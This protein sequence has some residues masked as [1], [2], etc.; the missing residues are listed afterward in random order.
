MAHPDRTPGRRRVA[1][2]LAA[3]TQLE[4]AQERIP[5]CFLDLRAD[6]VPFSHQVFIHGLGES[7][8]AQA[9]CAV[10]ERGLEASCEFVFPTSAWFEHQEP[11]RN[12]FGNALVEA[13]VEM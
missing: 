9:V 7:R 1:S 5:S 11:P 6:R 2:P 12:A 3:A 8:M 4:R 10:R 13:H